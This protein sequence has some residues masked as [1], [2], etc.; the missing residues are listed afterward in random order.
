MS[1][2]VSPKRL[3]SNSEF[4]LSSLSLSSLALSAFSGVRKLGFRRRWRVS[5]CR[6]WRRRSWSRCA[7]WSGS[8]SRSFSGSSSRAW[9]S[10]RSETLRR[11]GTRMV[12]ATTSSRKKKASTTTTSSSSAPRY[13]TPFLK[14][15]LF[16]FFFSWNCRVK[17]MSYMVLCIDPEDFLWWFLLVLVCFSENVGAFWSLCVDAEKTVKGRYKVCIFAISLRVGHHCWV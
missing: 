2:K 6:N 1:Q 8:S 7:R 5:C 14:V 3:H 9:R 10:R 16:Q 13:R 4:S 11:R 12:T 15:E 17:S